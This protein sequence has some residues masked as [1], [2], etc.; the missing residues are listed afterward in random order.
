MGKRSDFER[1]PRDYYPT[2]YS[3]VEPLLPHLPEQF[4]FAEPCAGDRRLI[5]HLQ[6]NGGNCRYAF[7]IEP[8]HKK[9]IKQDALEHG[10]S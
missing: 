1:I 9:V 10:Y 8:M 4:D 7:D 6:K 5:E 2:P 3:A